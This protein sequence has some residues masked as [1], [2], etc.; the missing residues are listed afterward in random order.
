MAGDGRRIGPLRSGVM[1]FDDAPVEIRPEIGA[2]FDREWERLAAPGTWWSGAERVA[3]AGT[4]RAARLGEEPPSSDLPGPAA[5]AAALLGA[6]PGRARREWV[7]STAAELGDP[8][9]V[10]LLGV[11]A[12]TAAVDAFHRALG[13]ALPAFPEPLPGEPARAS[14]PPLRRRAAW[15]PMPPG[16]IAHALGLVPAEDAAQEDLHGPLYLT[17]DGMGDMTFSRGLDRAQM[18]LV[19][20]RTSA[21]NEC[22]Y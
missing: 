1:R 16:S 18:E 12:R 20:A 11:T 21:L 7:E 13:F 10:E 19:A 15:V 22:F 2:A 17:Y 6:R 9:Y 5:E 8:A 4:A 3:I 14:L